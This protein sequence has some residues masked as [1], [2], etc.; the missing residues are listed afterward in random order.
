MYKVET[1]ENALHNMFRS[2][3]QK[4]SGNHGINTRFDVTLFLTFQLVYWTVA[5]AILEVFTWERKLSFWSNKV[6]DG[7]NKLQTILKTVFQC[8]VWWIVY[9]YATNT[10]SSTQTWCFDF[11]SISTVSLFFYCIFLTVVNEV[12]CESEWN[13]LAQMKGYTE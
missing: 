6:I 5:F 1:I 3:V 9:H 4:L 13:S 10:T 8:H 7:W 12:V 11:V 2:F